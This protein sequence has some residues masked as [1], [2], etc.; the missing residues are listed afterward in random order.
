MKGLSTIYQQDLRN[1]ARTGYSG[2]MSTFSLKTNKIIGQ[3][4]SGSMIMPGSG[5]HTIQGAENP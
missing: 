2:G 5:N 3:T 1:K 4:Q